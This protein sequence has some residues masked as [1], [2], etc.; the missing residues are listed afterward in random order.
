MSDNVNDDN[1]DDDDDD[2]DGDGACDE[3]NVSVVDCHRCDIAGAM[4]T[5]YR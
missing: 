4:L 1:E 5:F 3:D 2:D